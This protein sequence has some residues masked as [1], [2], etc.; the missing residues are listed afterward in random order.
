MVALCVAFAATSATAGEPHQLDELAID[1]PA[2]PEGR[3]A[4]V[5][6]AIYVVVDDGAPVVDASWLAAQLDEANRHFAELEVGFT[7]A[8]IRVLPVT[9]AEVETR[10]Q[11]DRLG[12]RR[13]HRGLVSV[14]VVRRLAN[15]DAPGDINGVHWRYRANRDRRWIIVS[16]V[17][18]RWTL[19]HELG[20]FFGLPHST[21]VGSLMNTTPRTEPPIATRVFTP[22]DI[23]ALRRGRDRLFRSGRL[24][25]RAGV[26]DR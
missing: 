13:L 6:L 5:G 9:A 1:L 4:C 25:R 2:C 16:S 20:H 24:S 11:R 10:A 8:A 15:V 23:T 12:R 3:P 22:D 7:A 26:T 19:A 18:G 17:A 21:D 14:F